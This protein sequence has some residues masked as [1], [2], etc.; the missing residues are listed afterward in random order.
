[1]SAEEER[2]RHLRF[3]PDLLEYALVAVDADV[4]IF[5]ADLM[6]LIIDESPIFGCSIVA[7]EHPGLVVGKDC[8]VKVGDLAPLQARVSWKKPSEP[9][10]IRIGL[11]FLE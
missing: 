2:R 4:P 9:G 5:K 3:K 7:Y 6:A 10:L 1:M 8:M 11:E